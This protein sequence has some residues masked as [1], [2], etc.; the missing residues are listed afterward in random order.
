M[1]IVKKAGVC[2]F[3]VTRDDN[4]LS[5]RGSTPK[6][7]REVCEKRKGICPR[8]KDEFIIEDMEGDYIY[9]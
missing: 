6:Q 8:Y 2:R 4:K 3:A 9:P 7:K 1:T 5:I